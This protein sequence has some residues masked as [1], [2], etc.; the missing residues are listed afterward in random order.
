MLDRVERG[1]QEVAPTGPVHSTASVSSKKGK[2]SDSIEKSGKDESSPRITPADFPELPPPTMMFWFGQNETMVVQNLGTK[3][4]DSVGAIPAG[5][6][7][8]ELQ[9]KMYEIGT[10][11]LDAWSK[12]IHETNEMIKRELKSQSYREKQAEKGNLG[13]EAYLNTLTPDQRANMIESNRLTHV[14]RI[15]E[16]FAQGLDDI[17]SK[18]KAGDPAYMQLVVPLAGAAISNGVRVDVPSVPGTMAIGS[19]NVMPIKEGVDSVLGQVASS[20]SVDLATVA[21][22]FVNRA[23]NF[24]TIMT[25]PAG[26]GTNAPKIDYE[27]A[28]NYAKQILKEVNGSDFNSFAMAIITHSTQEGEK[29]EPKKVTTLIRM[30]KV[31]MLST[32]LAFL[33]K[34]ESSFGGKGGGIGGKEFVSL[35]DGTIPVK[36]GD[37]KYAL[38]ESIN[39]LL[40]PPMSP[41]EKNQV[42]ATL[43]NWVDSSQGLGLIKVSP[44]FENLRMDRGA[45]TIAV[46]A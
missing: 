18:A 33:Y 25:F 5:I 46:A 23:A 42:L 16:G 37:P 40:G 6:V 24:A 4:V 1:S 14:G 20:Y 30:L 2:S 3:K 19:V 26:A 43:S 10:Q 8:L 45:A 9:R 31:A 39:E 13:Y 34:M 41:V 15:H 29:L 44:L 22:F 27:F 21:T 7:A 28:R 38:V 36:E 12:S 17:I 32:A 35:L 11:V